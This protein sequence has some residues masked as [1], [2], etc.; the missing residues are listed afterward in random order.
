VGLLLDVK[1]APGLSPGAI[2]EPVQSAGLS[3]RVLLGVRSA[4]EIEAFRRHDDN[5][6]FLG[7]VPT[8]EAIDDFI[9]AGAQAIRLWPRWIRK[10]PELVARLRQRDVGT[11]V[12][13]GK[14]D[15]ERLADLASLGIEG[16]ITDRPATAVRAIGCRPGTVGAGGS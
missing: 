16:V 8:P 7:F 1:P 13:T 3:S 14:A 4:E 15:A 2:V 10:Y 11:W 9:E 12:T 6:R 5:L